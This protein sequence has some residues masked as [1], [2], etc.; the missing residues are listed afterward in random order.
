MA[1]IFSSAADVFAAVGQLLGQSDWLKVQQDRIDLFAQATDDHQWIHV[2]PERAAAGPFGVCIAHGFLT[3]ALANYF[4]PQ[5]VH[6]QN[7]RMGI[8]YGCDRVRFP[9]AVKAGQRIRGSGE[10]LKA[11]AVDGGVQA[12]IRIVIDIDGETRPACIVDTIS[13]YYFNP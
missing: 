12:T 6:V 11:E 5:I 7:M 8:N 10:L 1:T 4:L 13:R 2:D 9:T 3:L